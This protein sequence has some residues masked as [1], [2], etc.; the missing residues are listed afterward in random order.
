MFTPHPTEIGHCQSRHIV[1][2]AKIFDATPD[3]YPATIKRL[4]S[5]RFVNRCLR[6][7]VAVGWIFC[8]QTGPAI[9]R[10]A[11]QEVVFR[12]AEN[13]T[14]DWFEINNPAIHGTLK[15]TNAPYDNTTPLN[16][17]VVDVGR[18][19]LVYDSAT[20]N[21]QGYAI[22]LAGLQLV[23]NSATPVT[24][25]SL[26]AWPDAGDN[27]GYRKADGQ[28]YYH[29]SDSDQLRQLEFGPTGMITG[30]TAIGNFNG[31]DAPESVSGGDLDFSANGSLWLSG[32]NDN[33]VSKL[34]DFDFASLDAISTIT[35]PHIYNGMTFNSAGDT[36]Y[37]YDATSGQYGTVNTT[38][39]AFSQVLD[40]DLAFFGSYGDLATGTTNIAI[41]PEPASL[42]LLGLG[43]IA[44]SAFRSLTFISA[45]RRAGG[46]K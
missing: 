27:A 2:V 32:H 38:T 3:C 7:I 9:V 33:D 36:L 45:R 42:G 40:T 29:P 18:N 34:W 16:A 23:P 39:G 30:F 28:V 13:S 24:I 19:R 37:G 17:A 10:A 12:A 20:D 41:V 11:T 8:W 4:A 22:S 26:G 6:F 14:I 1:P 15:V 5:V 21:P 46:R 44:L 43:G 25:T 35:L 31:G